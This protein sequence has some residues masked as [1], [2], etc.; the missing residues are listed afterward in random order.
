MKESERLEKLQAIADTM[1]CKLETWVG[2]LDMETA[3]P[4]AIRQICG[5]LNDLK[6]L[7]RD[8]EE[9]QAQTLTVTIEGGM[10]AW[11]N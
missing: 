6:D 1:T 8:L 7:S 9:K 10:E 5:T 2:S 11:N 4:Q 3:N